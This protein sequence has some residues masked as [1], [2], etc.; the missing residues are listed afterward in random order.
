MTAHSTHRWLIACLLLGVLLLNAVAG[1]L[2]RGENAALQ[3]SGLQ[4]SWCAAG[5]DASDPAPGGSAE[6]QLC[7]CASQL[8]AALSSQAPAAPV[9]SARSAG[10]AAYPAQPEPARHWPPAHPGAPPHA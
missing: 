9:H 3:L 5:S 8:A 10:A 4:S 2:L 1:S 6:C 7:T